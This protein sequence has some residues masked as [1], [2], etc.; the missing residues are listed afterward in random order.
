MEST[1]QNGDLEE[2]IEGTTGDLW[3][4]LRDSIRGVQRDY[5][6]GPVG[7]AVLLL[8]VPMV[9]ETMAESIFAVVDIFFVSKLEDLQ[10]EDILLGRIDPAAIPPRR[11]AA[12]Q[13]CWDVWTDGR[14][15]LRALPGISL[16]ER[17]RVFFR[18]FAAGGMLLP[19]HWEVF[20]QLWEDRLAGQEGILEALR[21]LPPLAA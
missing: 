2:Q 6:S 20:H 19:R 21:R 17:R 12:F 11:S 16:P 10:L 7:R 18:A 9:I 1:E 15:K 3:R 13:I 5:T 4:D 8:A 14:L